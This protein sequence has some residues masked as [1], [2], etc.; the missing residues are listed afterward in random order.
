M[1]VCR[2]IVHD[3]LIVFSLFLTSLNKGKEQWD[4]RYYQ[5]TFRNNKCMMVFSTY[6]FLAHINKIL[7]NRFCFYKMRFFHLRIFNI[8]PL[9]S[10]NMLS[11]C[12]DLRIFC[13]GIR[14]RCL[15]VAFS[16]VEI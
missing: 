11:K 5:Y 3:K 10:W 14:L 4:R 2:S 15:I 6:I 13:C 8:I 1:N 7:V 9:L 12:H 16:S